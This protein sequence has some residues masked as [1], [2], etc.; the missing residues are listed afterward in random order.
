[1]AI[2]RCPACGRRISSVAK[3][4]PHCHEPVGE[5][6]RE[7]RYELARKRWRLKL[8]RARNLT[9]LAMG[10]VVVGTLVW[11]MTPPQ[12]LAPPISTPAALLLGLGV[13]G[14]LG[15]WGWMLWLRYMRAPDRSE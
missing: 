3:A 11:W 14:Y 13:A 12:G 7:E 1:M 9:Y 8:Y 5:L 2:I 4:C 6:D 15:S 10:M